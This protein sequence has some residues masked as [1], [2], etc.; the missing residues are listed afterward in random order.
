MKNN[1]KN[2]SH[3]HEKKIIGNG[4]YGFVYSVD[5]AKCGNY[6]YKEIPLNFKTKLEIDSMYKLKKI[7]NFVE[8]NGVAFDDN[9]K[10]NI[11]MSYCGPNKLNLKNINEKDKKEILLKLIENV[12]IMNHFGISHNDMHSS[13]IL[14]NPMPTIIDFGC[15]RINL[16]NYNYNYRDRNQIKKHFIPFDY[17]MI[18]SLFDKKIDLMQINFISNKS[19]ELTFTLGNEH[20]QTL[21]NLPEINVIDPIDYDVSCENVIVLSLKE[22]ILKI[23][24]ENTF[25]GLETKIIFIFIAIE[26][27]LR[28]LKKNIIN[29]DN[30]DLYLKIITTI[31]YKM[32]HYHN[33]STEQNYDAELN[34]EISSYKEILVSLDW[35][36]FPAKLIKPIAKIISNEYKNNL[37][38]PI[39]N[40]LNQINNIK[41]IDDL[42][43]ILLK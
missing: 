8:I 22:N 24:S 19:I 35:Q 23:I 1:E 9:N 10:I 16:F 18:F 30:K 12:C 21:V 15:S 7:K 17:I 2:N 33:N 4:L 6:I 29:D 3:K 40:F 26:N 32:V 27:F 14:M 41:K 13:N 28:I 43:N 34:R 11:I 31:A 37:Y 36:I 20:I 38:Y 39:E 42:K 5:C 25:F